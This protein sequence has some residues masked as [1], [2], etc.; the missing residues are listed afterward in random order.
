M[1]SRKVSI[2]KT[3]LAIV[4]GEIA[5]VL[6]TT[7]AQEVIYDGISYRSSS[8]PDIIIGGMLTV[9][10]AVLAG[11]V[12]SFIGGK[13]NHRPHGFIS[14]LIIMEMTYLISSGLT[15]DPLWFDILAGLSLVA[16]VWIGFLIRRNIKV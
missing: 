5:L 2:G 4:L 12:A 3:V 6:L 15:K 8:L 14:L 11:V 9:L 7:V 16:G 10:A 1:T 13:E